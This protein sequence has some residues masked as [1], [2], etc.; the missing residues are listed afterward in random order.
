MFLLMEFPVD[1]DTIMMIH[2]LRGYIFN[3]INYVVHFV[4]LSLKILL[5]ILIAN[6]EL[7]T[8]SCADPK[9]GTGGLDPPPPPWKI[10]KI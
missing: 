8:F 10:T 2:I 4:F 9:G 3:F 1:I 7:W 5:P 6:S